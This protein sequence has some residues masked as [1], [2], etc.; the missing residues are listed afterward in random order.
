MANIFANYTLSVLVTNIFCQF[1]S[2]HY[3]RYLFALVTYF[4]NVTLNTT[5]N[6]CFTIYD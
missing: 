1:I 4:W 3:M 6:I 2:R 5:Y